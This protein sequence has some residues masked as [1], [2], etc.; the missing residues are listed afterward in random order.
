MV[1][2]AQQNVLGG[3]DVKKK[4]RSSLGAVCK[5]I[6]AAYM[7]FYAI[8]FFV[9]LGVALYSDFWTALLAVVV[10]AVPGL[11]LWAVGV[12]L[13]RQKE[14]Q[15]T[16]AEIKALLGGGGPEEAAGDEDLA[17]LEARLDAALEDESPDEAPEET[18]DGED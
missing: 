1:E 6:G 7:L 13:D 18:P 2:W 12:L 17:E 3:V 15:E 9:Q 5:I 14:N 4:T 8:V 16:L 11:T 10:A